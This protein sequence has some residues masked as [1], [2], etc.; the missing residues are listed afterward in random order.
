MEKKKLS[1]FTRSDLSLSI[2]I[3]LNLSGQKKGPLF[4]ILNLRNMNFT[5]RLMENQTKLYLS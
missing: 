2:E 5:F 3:N 1:L 4:N